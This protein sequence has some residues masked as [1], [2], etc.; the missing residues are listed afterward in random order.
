MFVLLMLTDFP[1]SSSM[2]CNVL[3]NVFSLQCCNKWIFDFFPSHNRIKFEIFSSLDKKHFVDEYQK[4]QHFD[5]ILRV[6][7]YFCVWWKIDIEPEKFIK[8]ELIHCSQPEVDSLLFFLIFIADMLFRIEF[9]YVEVV[10]DQLKW[11]NPFLNW[12]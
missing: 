6:F 11:K 4:I 9:V 1:S 8:V 10:V 5:T 7:L 3:F 12:K 2:F